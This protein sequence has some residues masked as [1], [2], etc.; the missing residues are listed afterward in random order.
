MTYAFPDVVTIFSDL[1]YW[2]A[3]QY[4]SSV[5]RTATIGSMTT[6]FHSSPC[7]RLYEYSFGFLLLDVMT[8]PV[9]SMTKMSYILLFFGV[10][11]K[12]IICF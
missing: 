4:V 3:A 1:G 6:V 12:S 10:A 11:C 9:G 7:F 2:N 8:V 5:S